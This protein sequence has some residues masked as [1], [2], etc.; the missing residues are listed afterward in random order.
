MISNFSSSIGKPTEELFLLNSFAKNHP[1]STT[2]E[3]NKLL[4]NKGFYINE[5][6]KT[7]QI[8]I[9]KNTTFELG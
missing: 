3:L 5:F 1:D 7:S 6:V 4:K 9:F 2:S 8:A